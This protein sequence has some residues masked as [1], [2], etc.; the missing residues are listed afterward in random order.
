MKIKKIAL[1][2]VAFCLIFYCSC[3]PAG[4]IA[5]HYSYE[6]ECLGVQGDGSQTLK[7][8]GKGSNKMIAASQAKINAIKD[9]L[10]KGISKGN[11]GCNVRPLIVAVNAQEKHRDYF[12][13]FFG[14]SGTYNKFVSN[15]DGVKDTQ[16]VND[17]KTV[18]GTTIKVLRSELRKQ[19]VKDK[20]L[21][22]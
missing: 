2:I 21:I 5:A 9:V 17:S 1:G 4:T 22:Q 3:K 7:A 12:L 19:L 14:T 15:V 18:C 10:F 16:F 13:A 8:W 6:T 11:S 20:I